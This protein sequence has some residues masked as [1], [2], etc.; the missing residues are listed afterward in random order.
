MAQARLVAFLMKKAVERKQDD[1]VLALHLNVIASTCS[2]PQFHSLPS[3]A[4]L[5][6]F[7]RLIVG[8]IDRDGARSQLL[9]LM[10]MHALTLHLGQHVHHHVDKDTMTAL[11]LRI[12]GLLSD[13]DTLIVIHC[14]A[15]LSNLVNHDD[16]KQLFNARGKNGV[17]TLRLALNTAAE[18]GRG[19]GIEVKLLARTL[20]KLVISLGDEDFMVDFVQDELD[21]IRHVIRTACHTSKDISQ[22]AI[23]LLCDFVG[24]CPGGLLQDEINESGLMSKLLEQLESHSLVI[25]YNLADTDPTVTDEHHQDS[26]DN[27]CQAISILVKR[28]PLLLDSHALV[29]HWTNL[30]TMLAAPTVRPGFDRALFQTRSLLRLLGDA[31][32]LYPSLHTTLLSA[33]EK[34]HADIV[35][36]VAQHNADQLHLFTMRLLA[37]NGKNAHALRL[38]FATSSLSPD[39][40]RTESPPMS[41]PAL[42][43]HHKDDAVT[44][45][46]SPAPQPLTS[47][48]INHIISLQEQSQRQTEA[49]NAAIV[50]LVSSLQLSSADAALQEVLEG[51]RVAHR[52]EREVLQERIDTLETRMQLLQNAYDLRDEE[53][54]QARELSEKVFSVINVKRRPWNRSSRSSRV[55]ADKENL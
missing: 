14:L 3:N 35:D 16:R 45:L 10:V 36:L 13:P 44:S 18:Q 52:F 21:A 54:A 4:I 2:A 5:T 46:T 47:A 17:K 28:C 41:A 7:I 48:V 24:A 6:P 30:I 43:S 55:L 19:I 32:F 9:N 25:R 26:F 11:Y 8:R 12:L 27:K 15:C 33:A 49:N 29:H 53:I 20:A 22:P 40:P 34:E 51:E 31:L 38:L 1:D 39:A 42:E 50:D 23:N 37:M